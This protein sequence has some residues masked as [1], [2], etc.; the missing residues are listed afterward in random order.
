MAGAHHIYHPQPAQAALVGCG[1]NQRHCCRDVRD[2]GAVGEWV[3]FGVAVIP[4]SS[5]RRLRRRCVRRD[6]RFAEQ[7]EN[8]WYA[9][10][11]F[12][13]RRRL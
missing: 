4:L 10:I 12:P 13:V 6:R 11:L 1:A 5:P 3:P 2:M 9:T 8:V 7:A